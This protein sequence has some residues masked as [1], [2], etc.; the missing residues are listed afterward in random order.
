MR[1]EY[2]LSVLDHIERRRTSWTSAPW[3]NR[4]PLP[5]AIQ[6]KLHFAEH[7][8]LRFGLD[9]W[10]LSS[11]SQWRA[12]WT[13]QLSIIAIAARTE[14]L[15]PNTETPSFERYARYTARV[16]QLAILTPRCSTTF[17]LNSTRHRWVSSAVIM[18]P[19][20]WNT[21]SPKPQSKAAGSCDGGPAP[22]AT[23]LL[24]Q[25]I[26]CSR[27]DKAAGV[28]TTKRLSAIFEGCA[29][30]PLGVNDRVTDGE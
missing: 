10:M 23:S 20:T 26:V 29:Q 6:C 8:L 7:G 16:S 2:A 13:R 12:A 24:Q 25:A 21:R 14:K 30:L 9:R 19:V 11:R 3:A 5:K 4:A 22:A 17:Y 18:R 27:H 15:A 1:S 28:G